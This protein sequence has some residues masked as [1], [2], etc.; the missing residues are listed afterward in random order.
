MTPSWTG[1][2]VREILEKS[3]LLS[4]QIRIAEADHG[5]TMRHESDLEKEDMS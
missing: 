1:N 3:S 2:D 5:L 4:V